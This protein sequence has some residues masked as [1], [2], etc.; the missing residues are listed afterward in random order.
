M[1]KIE[2]VSVNANDQ[3]TEDVIINSIELT[4]GGADNQPE[5]VGAEASP[6]ASST[7]ETDIEEEKAEAS[8]TPA[9]GEEEEGDFKLK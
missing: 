3:P 6:S 9:I 8:S 4:K 2:K 1:E 5:I 7:P